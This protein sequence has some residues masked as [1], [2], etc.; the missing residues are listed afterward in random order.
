ME[1]IT[2]VSRE[3]MGTVTIEMLKGTD[4]DEAL[5]RVKNQVEKISS[6]PVNY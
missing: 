1:R 4:M 5:T 2:S 6:F 3:N